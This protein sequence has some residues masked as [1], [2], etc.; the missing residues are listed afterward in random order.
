MERTHPRVWTV[1]A[2]M[3]EQNCYV[4]AA[5]DVEECV[6]ID[7]GLEP[8]KIIRLVSSQALIPKAI[9]VTHGHADHIA[10]MDAISRRWPEIEIV[11]GERDA[12][13]LTNA[14]LNLSA[15]F[16]F[17][18]TTPPPTRLVREGDRLT[19]AGLKFLVREVP[20]HSIGH[21]IYVVT[22]A[23]PPLAF[24]GD[25]IFAGSIGRTDFPDGNFE[26]LSSGIQGKI[27]T[28]PDETELWSGHGEPTTVGRE[29]RTN[30][31]VRG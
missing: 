24:V 4:V 18:L 31:F 12:E 25:V 27:Y 3:F 16:G 1:V 5:D 22:P 17:P 13:K 8:G 15:D 28:L 30:P 11:V 7:P 21:V 19:L 23:D 29:R 2:T 26:D 6:I 20:G 10:G 9:L 14:R